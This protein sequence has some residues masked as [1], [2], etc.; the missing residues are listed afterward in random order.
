M[1]RGVSIFFL[2]IVV[3]G[4]LRALKRG[5]TSQMC[6]LPVSDHVATGYASRHGSRSEVG[7]VVGAARTRLTPPRCGMVLYSRTA[8]S[9]TSSSWSSSSE[10]A[11]ALVPSH[12]QF[13]AWLRQNKIGSELFF[14]IEQRAPLIQPNASRHHRQPRKGYVPS[15]CCVRCIELALMTR[16]SLFF[17][18]SACVPATT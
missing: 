15:S 2:S 16:T 13:V 11:A 4:T 1:K 6:T 18:V 14:G 12:V 7:V 10:A 5:R 17:A 8:S 9:S 3:P